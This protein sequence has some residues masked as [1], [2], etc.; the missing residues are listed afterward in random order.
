MTICIKNRRIYDQTTAVRD[1]L[2]RLEERG[3][4]VVDARL[5]GRAPVIYIEPDAAAE[6]LEG[7][8]YMRERLQGRLVATYVCPMLGCQV[9]W[10]ATLPTPVPDNLV[11]MNG[12]GVAA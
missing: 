6:Q 4:K 8:V 2:A 1:A 7:A 5:G 3:C 11:R 9:R 10:P 12:A